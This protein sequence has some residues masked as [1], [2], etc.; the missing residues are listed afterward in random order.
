[1]KNLFLIFFLIISICLFG[2]STII[3]KQKNGKKLEVAKSDLANKMTWKTAKKA[4]E[5]L[6]LGWRI[7]TREELN[8]LYLN[9]DAIGG[10]QHKYYWSTSEYAADKYNYGK[11]WIQNFGHGYQFGYDFANYGFH[12]LKVR[13][14]KDVT[15]VN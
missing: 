5:K 7:P 4:C 1:M 13:L 11:A 9:K 8:E 10:F 6:E 3:I 2:Q 12:K 14:V 15:F